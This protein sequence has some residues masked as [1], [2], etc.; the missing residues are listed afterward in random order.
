MKSKIIL[1]FIAGIMLVACEKVFEK[2]NLT[3][4]SPEDIWNNIS[5]AQAYV[6]NLYSLFM[7]EISYRSGEESDEAPN[8]NGATM[9]KI[10]KGEA[11]IE[12]FKYWPYDGIRKINFLLEEVESGSLTTEEIGFLKGQAYF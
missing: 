7:P 9:N 10:L 2:E 3:A 4:I 6:D 11:T 12:T 8:T 1:L 5:Y